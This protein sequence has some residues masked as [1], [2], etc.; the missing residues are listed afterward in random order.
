MKLRGGISKA[1]DAVVDA[2][3][4]ETVLTAFDRYTFATPLQSRTTD[5]A[6]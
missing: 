5:L 3:D 2:F 6:K 1:V 4:E